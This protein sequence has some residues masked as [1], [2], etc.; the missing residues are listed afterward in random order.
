MLYHGKAVNVLSTKEQLI[1][2][3]EKLSE[4]ELIFILEFLKKIFRLD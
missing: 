3:I 2:I 4:N 1:A